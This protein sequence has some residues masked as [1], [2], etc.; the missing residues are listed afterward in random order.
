MPLELEMRLGQQF[1]HELLVVK[2]DS[3]LQG[4]MRLQAGGL[5][6]LLG[7]ASSPKRQH[8]L[9]ASVAAAERLFVG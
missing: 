8:I 5:R 3:A 2:G 4:Q 1:T 7:R 6:N 9:V